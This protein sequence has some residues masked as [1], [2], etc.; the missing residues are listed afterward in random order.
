MA[1]QAADRYRV[2]QATRRVRA[3]ME[4]LWLLPLDDLVMAYGG[5][6]LDSLDRLRVRGELMRRRV[7]HEAAAIG[8]R[9]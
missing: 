9:R 7:S 1:D 8:F 3:E 6:A 4:W 2:E 5:A